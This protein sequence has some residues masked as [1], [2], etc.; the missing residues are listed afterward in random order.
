[1]KETNDEKKLQNQVGK[2][3]KTVKGKHKAEATIGDIVFRVLIIVVIF[4]IA[5]IAY[6]FY[7]QGINDSKN[8]NSYSN[9]NEVRK[10][11]KT[12]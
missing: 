10:I 3:K 2:K 7:I 4:F 12:N 5:V 9:Q 1:M 8:V 11:E 6:S